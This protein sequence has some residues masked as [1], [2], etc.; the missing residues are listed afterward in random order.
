MS[1]GWL[2]RQWI[3]GCLLDEVLDEMVV[4]EAVH[5]HIR[6]RRQPQLPQ[7]LGLKY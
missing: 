4:G 2:K 7:D 5:S 6:Y 1:I 3:C